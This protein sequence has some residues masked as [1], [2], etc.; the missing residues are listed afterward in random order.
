MREAHEAAIGE[1]NFVGLSMEDGEA[2]DETCQVK[3][4]GVG[5]SVSNA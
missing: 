4:L 3:L 1:R 2:V 5:R